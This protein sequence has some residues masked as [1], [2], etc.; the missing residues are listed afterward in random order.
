MKLF[1]LL[2]VSIFCFSSY[3]EQTAKV[4]YSPQASSVWA[5]DMDKATYPGM[6]GT[7]HY[8]PL[9]PTSLALADGQDLRR[10]LHGGYPISLPIH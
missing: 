8:S 3:A 5:M 2:I 9:P 7:R 1:I 6:I 10:A 4:H